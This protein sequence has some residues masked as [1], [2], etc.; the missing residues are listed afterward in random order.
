M[1]D[2]WA[3]YAAPT[4]PQNAA[5][6]P[7]SQYAQK[8]AGDGNLSIPDQPSAVQQFQQGF[9]KM[10][11]LE[12]H[13]MPHSMSDVGREALKG[14]DNLGRATIGMLA[15]LVHPL[16]TLQSAAN[17][18][19]DPLGGV[20]EVKHAIQNPLTT[21]EQLA[22]GFIAGEGMSAAKPL[23][24]AMQRGGL[25]LGNNV[26]GAR[27]PKPFKYGA[28]PARG[29]YEEGV[30]PALSKHSASMKLEEALPKA[31]Q[32][33]S[34]AVHASPMTAP[35]SDIADSIDKPITSAANTM[36]GFGGGKSL[37]PIANL[38][39]SMEEKAPNANQPIYGRNAPTDVPAPDLWHSI[40]NLD[41]N[42]RFNPDPEVEGVNELRREMR[43]GL[44]GNLETAVPGLKPISQRYGDL[45]GAQESLDRTMHSGTGLKKLLEVP[46]TPIES[47]VGRGMYSGGKMAA[48]SA[49]ILQGASRA[50]ALLQTLRK[51]E[52]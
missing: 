37:D 50:N 9:D 30:L 35:A 2:K 4:K 39:S 16:K 19:A 31:G 27:G 46:M 10:T 7:W 44:R 11:Q 28:N 6:D 18:E 42:T 36:S 24:E 29:A 32:R 21:A 14:Y 33:V 13:Q 49:P 1:P 52:Q 47:T 25:E 20:E 45:A 34:D 38:W 15:P 22:P 26:L 51:K 5:S 12:P 17:T 8:D 41:K 40:R 3:Q 48:A 23:G 43:G